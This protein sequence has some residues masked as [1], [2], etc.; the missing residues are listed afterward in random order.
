VGFQVLF[1]TKNAEEEKMSYRSVCVAAWVAVAVVTAAHAQGDFDA[2]KVKAMFAGT[3]WYTHF[4]G[5]SSTVK[6]EADG[7]LAVKASGYGDK[8][9]T[10]T[11]KPTGPSSVFGDKK[12]WVM[13]P[14]KKELYVTGN[15]FFVYYRGKSMPPEYPFL[16]ETLAKQ[17]IVWVQ[18]GT[19]DRKTLAFNGEL[20]VASGKNGA[21]IEQHKGTHVF[22]G[23][24]FIPYGIDGR[25]FYLGRS[26][27]GEWFLRN[28]WKWIYKP[29]P[30]QPGDPLPPQKMARVRSPLNG[31]T[32]CRMDGKGK[33][34]LLTFNANGTVS[35]SAFPNE[36]PE[37]DPYDN[38]TVRYKLKDGA[39]RLTH[40]ADKK[41]LSRI[42]GKR[43]EVWFAGRQLP[44]VSMTE[45]QQLKQTL[46]DKSKAWVNW[47]DGK[48]TVY[49]FDDKT[50]NVTI[51]VDDGKP[52]VTRWEPL[53]AGCIRIGDEAFMVD[54][55]TLERTE[56]RLTLK[57]VTRES[58]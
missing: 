1:T 31:T 33:V 32:W 8:D 25:L 10:G 50:A 40:D 30:A 11:W 12:E 34:L 14:D 44:R 42:D 26:E 52:Q 17:G 46:A 47:D 16:R 24:A 39:R 55:D 22:G 28:S 21:E 45:T 19:G 18:Q 4:A 35:D 48:K 29:E 15:E 27:K 23:G 36:K 41:R 6:F 20:D 3:E 13:S 49:T 58:L 56:P 2:E 5:W 51:T 57:Q 9:R 43:Y 54:G 53:H 38:G 37:W 7:A